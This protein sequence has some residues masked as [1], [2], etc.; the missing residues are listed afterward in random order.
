L[1]VI[2]IVIGQLAMEHNLPMSN[3]VLDMGRLHDVGR[4]WCMLDMG[5]FFH[6]LCHNYWLKYFSLIP[7]H[8]D[9]V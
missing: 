7:S 8:S 2:V 4:G 1:Q 5:T 9:Q 3:M 6:L